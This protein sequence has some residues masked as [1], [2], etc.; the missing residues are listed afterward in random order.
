VLLKMRLKPR[1]I[2]ELLKRGKL[3]ITVVGLGYVGGPLA[4]Y[5]ANLGVKVIGVDKDVQKVREYRKC[6]SPIREP[7]L[8]ELLS[9]NI[10]QKRLIFSTDVAEATK[11]SDVTMIC[12]GTPVDSQGKPELHGLVSA[13]EQVGYGLKRGHIV[14]LRSTVPP[15][16]TEGLVR[17]ILEKNAGLKAGQDFALAFCPERTVEGRAL[18]ELKEVPHIVGGIDQQSTEIA[19]AVFR[20]FGGQVIKVNGC[21]VAE[22]AKLL[23]NIYRYVN[24]ALANEV[25]LICEKLKIDYVESIQA[26][27]VGPRTRMLMPGAGVGGSCL[28]KDTAM[29]IYLSRQQN[30]EPRILVEAR[31]L[32]KAMPRRTVM[33][34]KDAYNEMGKTIED[35]II[36][37]LGLAYKGE[38]DDLR[39]TVSKPIIDDL[40]SLE[41]KIRAYDPYVDLNKAKAL[42]TGVTVTKCL[43]DAVKKTDCIVIVTD[44][45]EFKE[46]DLKF[47]KSIANKR[48]AVVDGRQVFDP[49]DA[50]KA[51]FVYKG[52]GRN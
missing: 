35:S 6:K 21:K 34:V 24:V 44:H 17:N 16:T 2:S 40:M 41:A 36:T 52:I 7:R 28:N 15:G 4:V 12:V 51:G 47:L 1:A 43:R 8:N 3:V 19:E 10:K 49:S 48:A 27:N 13:V 46:L 20:F 29:T 33:L 26:A 42:F 31:K 50:V 45:K 18:K 22:M 9:K 14:I 37:I 39:E 11:K 38:T 5:L 25:A 30:L 23:D 32:N